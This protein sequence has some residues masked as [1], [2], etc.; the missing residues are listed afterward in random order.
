LSWPDL[1]ALFGSVWVIYASDRLL[2][3]WRCTNI[4]QLRRR[5]FFAACHRLPFVTLVAVV[6]P[7]VIAVALLRLRAAEIMMG[8]GLSLLVVTY[9]FWVHWCSPRA[10]RQLSK[11][12]AVGTLFAM[13]TTLPSWSA[14][15]FP[16]LF[17]PV[18]LFAG[19]CS[20]N[21]LAVDR[22]EDLETPTASTPESQRNRRSGWHRQS[23]ED[24]VMACVAVALLAAT[25]G[26]S[27]RPISWGIASSALLLALIQRN[28]RRF[29]PEQLRVLADLALALP[30]AAAVLADLVRG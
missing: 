1:A 13:G 29:S 7:A 10:P 6:G 21:C 3:A 19:L 14:R 16:A 2:D 24:F 20:L 25:T 30:A 26:G 28:R 11:E 4:G 27:I 17:L 8:L 15:G 22:W 18:I 23:P 5:H 9:L 12:L